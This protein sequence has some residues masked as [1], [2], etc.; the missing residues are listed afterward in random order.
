M[1]G[2]SFFL[3]RV[4]AIKICEPK[5][6][7]VFV[8]M[9]S[10]PF[11]SMSAADTDVELWLNNNVALVALFPLPPRRRVRTIT[12]QSDERNTNSCLSMCLEV[13]SLFLWYIQ[14]G[15]LRVFGTTH[16]TQ[17]RP[18]P[19]FGTSAMQ[20]KNKHAQFLLLSAAIHGRSTAKAKQAA[21]TTD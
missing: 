13:F 18:F 7:N 19:I 16:I 8:P 20:K 21:S 9:R 12:A 2:T 14:Q 5:W 6:K 4:H 1:L 17:T 10:G 11:H 3:K 15:W